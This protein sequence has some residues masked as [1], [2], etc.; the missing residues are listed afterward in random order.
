MAVA[1]DQVESW[2]RALKKFCDLTIDPRYLVEF[3]LKP[4]TVINFAR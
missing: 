4:G 2:Y 1:I 3:K